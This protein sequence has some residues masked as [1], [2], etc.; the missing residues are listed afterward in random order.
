RAAG[1]ATRCPPAPQSV[2]HCRPPYGV[3]CKKPHTARAPPPPNHRAIRGTAVAR[4]IAMPH[5]APPRRAAA[6]VI[7]TLALAGCATTRYLPPPPDPLATMPSLPEPPPEGTG[8]LAPVVIS[9]DIP[10]TV[11]RVVAY[12]PRLERH[13][14]PPFVP[15]TTIACSQTPCVLTLPYG[16]YELW[17]SGIDDH[18][19]SST[20]VL[21][22]QSNTVVLNHTL[23]QH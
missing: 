4:R 22:V 2:P 14:G 20:T 8:G 7:A 12:T 10:A 21:H 6:I 18:E 23:G 15:S 9:T 13:R 3:C 5:D 16:D 11:E 19:R 1:S 17:F